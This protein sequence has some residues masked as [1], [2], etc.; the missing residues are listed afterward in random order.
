MDLKAIA[1]DAAERVHQNGGCVPQMAFAPILFAL[2]DAFPTAPS[3][4]PEAA[5][6]EVVAWRSIWTGLTGRVV[7][8]LHD[9]KAEAMAELA[10][11]YEAAPASPLPE[12]GLLW[13]MH[14]RGPD[15]IYPAPDYETAVSWC[16]IANG[17]NGDSKSPLIRAVPAIWTG[18]SESHAAGL[19]EAIK[20]WTLPAAPTG[21]A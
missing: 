13:M 8:A 18:T 11:L 15:D 19:P 9:Q 2:Q 14:V 1:K 17:F 3:Q 5:G 16:D 4:T 6:L 10:R 20:G 21:D 12:G 7:H